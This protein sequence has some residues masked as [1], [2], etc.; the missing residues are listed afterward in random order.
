[1]LYEEGLPRLQA[2]ETNT[3]YLKSQGIDII[4]GETR[5]LSYTMPFV[6]G[7][8]LVVHLQELMKKDVNLFI[9]E[10]DRV[11]DTILR[12][13]EHVE[14]HP[15]YG[16]ILERGYID[17]IPLNCIVNEDKYM[18][19]DQEVCEEN[20]PANVIIFRAV[21]VTYAANFAM[22]N[23]LPMNYFFDRFNLTEELEYYS[24]KAYEF[25]RDLRNKVDLAPFW[26]KH[27]G[28]PNVINSNRQRINYSSDEYRR[29]FEDLFKD[30]DGKKIIVFGAGNFAKKFLA[31]YKDDYD[32]HCIVD[33]NSTKWGSE[34][35]GIKINDPAILKK[36]DAAEFK[37][38]IC[39]KNYISII[40][41]VKDMGV[42]SYGVYDPSMSYERRRP[43][44]SSSSSESSGKKKYR[45]GY[46]AGVFDMF[47]IGHL[48]LLRR[49]KEQC[50][51]LIV[52]VVTDE[53]VR[54]NKKTETV[55]PF[56]ERLEVVASC[57]YVDEAVEIPYGF[58][59]TEDA[60]YKYR[61][62]C[63]FSGSD[64]E[65]NP[66]WLGEK[67]FLNSKGVDLVFFPYTQSTSSSKLKE[68]LGLEENKQ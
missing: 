42:V 18:F 22:H 31:F 35:N 17:L 41:Q 9:K 14:V 1:M 23:T 11:R 50:E 30:V 15:K 59:G 2:L 7:K 55:I 20:Y 47:H 33:N 68:K 64:Y 21:I 63:Q 44:I 56:S 27:T 36:L 62:D 38:I 60:Y 53:A 66:L 61:F 51:Y 29:V 39:V 46:V 32:I 6:R 34:L 25:I 28:S 48:N 57:K 19:F 49:S 8:S 65:D 52:G 24:R 58:G 3:R 16:V 43:V 45:V 12:S 4:E 10:M 40:R 26:R 67:E 54:N 37:V 5:G 13:S